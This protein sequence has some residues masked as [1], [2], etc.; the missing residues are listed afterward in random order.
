MPFVIDMMG[1]S[2][3]TWYEVHWQVILVQFY[4]IYGTW[5]DVFGYFMGN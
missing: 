2:F 1:L 3:C 5:S 4:E